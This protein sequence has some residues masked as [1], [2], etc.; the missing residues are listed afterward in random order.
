MRFRP[1]YEITIECP[2]C[3]DLIEVE[4][5]EKGRYEFAPEVPITCDGCGYDDT[6]ELSRLTLDA[7]DVASEKYWIAKWTDADA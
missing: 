3:G 6:T 5:Y 2:E 7:N 4:F 1:H